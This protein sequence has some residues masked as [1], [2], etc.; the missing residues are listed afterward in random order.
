MEK[1]PTF[2]ITFKPEPGVDP[3]R[4]LRRLLKAALRC[5]GLRAVSTKEVLQEIIEEVRQ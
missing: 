3:V 2:T 4:A 1:R 5:Y